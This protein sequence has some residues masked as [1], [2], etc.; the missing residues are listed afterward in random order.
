MQKSLA[1][2]AVKI[3]E[4]MLEL[5]R[6]RE[7]A[8]AAQAAAAAAA[9]AAAA[10]AARAAFAAGAAQRQQMFEQMKMQQVR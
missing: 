3:Q 1:Q 6:Q 10:A 7:A 9:Q 2:M 4:E 5:K 8:L